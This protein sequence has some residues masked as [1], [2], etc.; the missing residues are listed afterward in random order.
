MEYRTDI[1]GLRAIAVTAVI[2][3]HLGYLPNGYLGVDIF[4][5]ISGFLI[6]SIIYGSAIKNAFS[7]LTFYQR[8]VRRI[9]PLLLFVSLVSLIIGSL[10]MLPEDL[11][12]LSQSVIASNFSINNILMY[13][14]SG[15]YWATKNEFKPLMHTW[16]LGVEEQYYLIF[17]FLFYFF[18][19]SKIRYSVYLV[20]ILTVV[21]LLAFV[22]QTD[23]ASRFY[24]IQY[25]FFQ[26]S[27]GG[28]G[29]I[30]LTRMNREARVTNILW[31][32][33]FIVT[34]LIILIAPVL[35]IKPVLNIFITLSTIGLLISGSAHFNKPGSYKT[36]FTN[37]PIVAVGKISFSI[38]MWHQVVFAF[39]RYILVEEMTVIWSVVLVMVTL[40]LSIITYTLI[41]NPFRNHQ[42]I[43]TKSVV[44]VCGTILVLTTLPAFYIHSISGIVKEVPELGLT[45]ADRVVKVNLFTSNRNV[46]IKYIDDIDALDKDFTEGDKLKV[47]VIGN[48]FGRDVSNILLEY[49]VNGVLEVR[50]I[51]IQNLYD[52]KATTRL[53]QADRILIA[54]KDFISKD[55][56]NQIEQFHGLTVDHSKVW[57][58]GTK[59]FGYHNGIHHFRY[60][61]TTNFLTYR[62]KMRQGVEQTNDKLRLEWSEKFIDLIAVVS[63]DEEENVLIYT[64]E[65]KFI[66]HDTLHLT[67]FGAKYF[68]TKLKDKLDEI[69]RQANSSSESSRGII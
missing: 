68:A 32:Y 26:L 24:L 13:I 5:V 29:A 65:G 9:I 27:I 62:T 48:S 57:L 15:N 59:D 58:F 44:L 8:R 28:L 22:L 69:F 39:G 16:S 38:Y 46:F 36:L 40:L 67:R 50:Y 11:E 3:F 17:P 47:L 54:A 66:S 18:Q 42:L 34:T 25:R 53:K 63:D 43:K 56:L 7:I 49:D 19:G 45:A 35:S 60:K 6:T 64:P 30:F 41:E 21:S 4:F 1:D 14:T 52:R 20:L 37:K 55:I 23:S 33:F 12:N 51:R 61:A 2:L 10:V 31:L